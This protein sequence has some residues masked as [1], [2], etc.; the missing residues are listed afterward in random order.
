MTSDFLRD[1][2]RNQC[3][4]FFAWQA[5][6]AAEQ[7]ERLARWFWERAQAQQDID[8]RPYVDAHGVVHLRGERSPNH[9]VPPPAED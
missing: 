9:D 7:K 2:Y 6:Q 3:A 8:D 4:D 1:S 5:R